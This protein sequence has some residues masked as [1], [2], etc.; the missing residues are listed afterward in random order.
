MPKPTYYVSPEKINEATVARNNIVVSTGVPQ[1]GVSNLQSISKSNPVIY[2]NANSNAYINSNADTITCNG[3]GSNVQ[4]SSDSNARNSNSDVSS[5]AYNNGGVVAYSSSD[6]DT[7][8]NSNQIAYTSNE[9]SVSPATSVTY[10]TVASPDNTGAI[11]SGCGCGKQLSKSLELDDSTKSNSDVNIVPRYFRI[12][13]WF[14][15]FHIVWTI[16]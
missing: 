16:D 8:T 5:D 7:V 6:S 2:N 12:F 4:I 3:A 13:H 15:R 10:T 11:D 14:H 9:P 1:I